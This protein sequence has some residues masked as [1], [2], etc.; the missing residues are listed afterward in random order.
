MSS[1]VDDFISI[2][3]KDIRKKTIF[4]LICI[5]LAVWTLIFTLSIGKYEISFIDSY[6]VFVNNLFGRGLG[7]RDDLIIWEYRVP[8]AILG[9]FVGASLAVG[10]AV[11]QSL[12]KNP[13]AEPFTMGISSGAFLG[14]VLSIVLGISIF[15]FFS[16]DQA[17][18]ANAF[19]LS[20]VPVILIMIIS[21]FRKTSPT[22]MILCGISIMYIFSSISTL[23]MVLSD[24]AHLSEAY[25]W[26]VGTLGKAKWST[27]PLIVPSMVVLM[28]ILF[29]YSR[30][31]NTLSMGDEGA[32]SLG[33]NPS[34]VRITC[35]SFVAILTSFAVC[36][37]GTIG[38]LGL[39]APHI[40][41]VFIGSNNKYLLPASA[42]FGALFLVFMDSLAKIVSDTGL[43][44][45]VISALIGGPVFVYILVKGRN[46]IWF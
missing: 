8:R 17:T 23:I 21:K 32:K 19:L 37:T 7:T 41:R 11:M 36:F 30:Q 12:M 15:P 29:F 46:K 13:L 43:P 2:Y 9:L 45:G 10:G 16:G 26:R 14:A 1:D 40:V 27:L 34:L 33:T 35:F 22:M 42:G 4:V 28:I 18:V 39:V 20:L 44:V 24:P 38:F 5:I 3:K 31:I 25:A 6:K